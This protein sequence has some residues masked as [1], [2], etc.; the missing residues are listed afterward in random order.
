MN[1]RTASVQSIERAK[2][3]LL[4]EEGKENQEIADIL[5]TRPNTVGKWRNKF[6]CLRMNGLKD[7]SRARSPKKYGEEF[8]K[9]I[10]EVLETKPPGGIAVWDGKEIAKV[11]KCS[12][13]PVWAVLRKEGIQLSRKRSWCVSTDPEFAKKAADIV[14][15]YLNPPENAL[16]ISI[17]ATE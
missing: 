12:A 15:L 17:G 11:L 2:I 9:K 14:G 10:F 3:I 5:N 4:A 7:D 1:Q 6:L 8:K 16:I 13:D